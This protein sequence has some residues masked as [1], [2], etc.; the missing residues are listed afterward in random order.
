MNPEASHVHP[1]HVAEVRDNIR[2]LREDR[3]LHALSRMWARAV[4]PY[5]YAYNFSWMG[6]PIVQVPQDVMALQELIF[7]VEPRVIVET[8]IAHGGSLVFHASML[9]LLGGDR[10]AIGVDR[11]IRPHNRTAL[12][13]HP[14]RE[15]FALVEGSSTDPAIVQQVYDLVDGRGPVLVVL[16]SDHTHEHVLA[17]L[18]AYAPL[19][20]AGSYLVV[21]DTLVSDLPEEL[22]AGKRWSRTSNPRSAVTEFLRECPRFSIDE[23]VDAKLLISVGPGGYLRATEDP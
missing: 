3:D 17:E 13:A 22:Y 12:E 4:A 8:G 18:R 15:R 9:S 20:G 6:R 21:L 14:M 19:V 2:R 16:D 7:K 1:D 5:K 23:D 11:E 10:L